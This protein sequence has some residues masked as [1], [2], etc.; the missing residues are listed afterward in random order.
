M[1][2]RAERRPLAAFWPIRLRDRLPEIPV[3]LRPGVADAVDRADRRA[4]DDGLAAPVA[5]RDGQHLIERPGRRKRLLLLSRVPGG[6]GMM[7]DG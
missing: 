4:G 5:A 7:V 2:S 1:V 3:P 6:T